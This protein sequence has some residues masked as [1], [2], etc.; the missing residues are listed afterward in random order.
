MGHF[1]FA[2]NVAHHIYI[3]RAYPVAVTAFGTFIPGWL[4]IDGFFI[5][6]GSLSKIK[7]VISSPVLL[8]HVKIKAYFRYN[9]K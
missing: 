7:I 9:E 2:L 3:H 6:S 5:R 4:Y 8:I 1:P